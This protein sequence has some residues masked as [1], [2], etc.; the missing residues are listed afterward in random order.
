MFLFLE[1]GVVGKIIAPKMSMEDVYVF[2]H[3]TSGYATIH[4]ERDFDDVVMGM[5]SEKGKFPGL[6]RQAPSNHMS[7]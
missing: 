7:T 4:G 6:L 5:D 3:R 2:I 1:K